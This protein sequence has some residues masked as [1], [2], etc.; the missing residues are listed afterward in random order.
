MA[1]AFGTVEPAFPVNF[2]ADEEPSQLVP[3]TV[4]DVLSQ[5]THDNSSQLSNDDHHLHKVSKKS[6]SKITKRF[7]KAAVKL[8]DCVVKPNETVKE[9][10]RRIKNNSA[11]REFRSR[12]KT[13]LE[14]MLVTEDSLRTHNSVMRNDLALVEEVVQILKDG[15]VNSARHF[16]KS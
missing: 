12:K 7:N 14:E 8:A 15:L 6:N 16:C 10:Q 3:V 2:L 9:A 13:K 4:D 5:V 1:E 11:S